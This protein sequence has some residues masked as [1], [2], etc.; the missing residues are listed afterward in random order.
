MKKV[1]SAGGKIGVQKTE[2]PGVGWLALFSDLDDRVLSV[3]NKSGNRG[4]T[5]GACPTAA[6]SVARVIAHL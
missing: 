4:L 6:K 2:V 5:T 3:G 1:E